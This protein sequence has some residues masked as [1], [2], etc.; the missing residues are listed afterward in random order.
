MEHL[1]DKEVRL[2]NFVKFV[3]PSV[4]MLV[5]I[6]LYYIIDSIFVSNFVGSDAL[7]SL[8]IVYPIQGIVWG[9][10]VML[11]AGSSAVVAIKMGEKKYR[12]A[13]EKFTLICIVSA[14]IGVAMIIAGF[15]FIDEIIG[16]LGATERLW[17]YCKGYAQI[18]ILAIPA[19]FLGVLFEYFIRV[20]G[21]PGFT[22]M[23]YLSGGIVHLGLDYVFIVVCDWGIKGAAWAT[24]AG[25]VT[26]MLIGAGYFV[27]RETQLKIVK[28][29]WDG[30]YIAHSMLNGSS[31][32]VSEASVGITTF[33]FNM[34]V[35][36]L[37]GEN[38]VAA[39]SIVLNSHYLL[40]S[41][42]LGYI[43]GVA[44]L[45]SYFYGAKEYLK[46]NV[47]L[48]YSRVFM[49]S[50]SVI[51]AVLCFICAPLIAQA[52]EPKGTPV[53][54]MA[55][56]GIRYL[57]AAFLFTGVNVF[58]SGFFTAY[59]NG[60]ISALISLSRAL[61]MVLVGAFLLSWLFGLHGVWMTLPFAEVTTTA[62]ALGMFKRY[63][64]VYHYDLL[65]RGDGKTA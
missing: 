47:F 30:R 18:L 32:M 2:G 39:L 64:N 22:L 56:T 33:F 65:Y 50:S 13:D 6:G 1:F 11:A 57:S 23:L 44:P 20:D 3:T 25:M 60:Q 55:E 48:K 16:F 15:I 53:Y 49:L 34:I 42:H 21:R 8:S 54:E 17:D 37:A 29:K 12:E 28:P 46:V 38:G 52:Y 26:V 9:V 31:E 41:V 45:I 14:A 24:L 40:I 35:I 63:K 19:A 61:I 36:R 5:V 4:I 7:A 58:A 10:S 62:L 59:G 51:L 27:F 43:T